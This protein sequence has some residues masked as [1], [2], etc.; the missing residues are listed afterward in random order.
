[1]REWIEIAGREYLTDYIQSGGGSVKFLCGATDALAEV[2]D[3][4]DEF[5]QSLGY[6]HLGLDGAAVKLHRIDY[7]FF[8]IA[9][10]IDWAGLALAYVAEGFREA[11]WSLVRGETPRGESGFDLAAMATENGVEETEIR[12][13]LKK[14]LAGLYSDYYM[15]Q[16]FRLAMVQLCKAQV[17]GLEHAAVP[18]VLWLRG[19]L[20]RIS[21]IKSAKI[22]QKIGRHNGRLMLQ[23][24]TYWLRRNDKPGL[25][26]T[27][28]IS[29]CVENVKRADR[30]E[31]IYY[32]TSSLTEVYEMLRQ[33][34]DGSSELIATFA[35]VFAPPEFLSDEKRGVDRYQALKMRIFDDVRNRGMQNPLSPLFR[36]GD[37]PS[38][39]LRDGEAA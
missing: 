28:D 21:E 14:R 6:I 23:S 35:A 5:A 38:G 4:L 1:M 9:K 13:V 24:L 36:L 18:T 8:E 11:G 39:A 30:K 17:A 26:L 10:Q 32:S 19:E 22:F 3:A 37:L 12:R 34:V 20:A 27:L 15:S 2:S 7:V 33:L 25:V 16:E 29:R 31:G